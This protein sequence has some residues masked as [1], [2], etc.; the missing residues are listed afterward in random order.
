ML[1]DMP[2]HGVSTPHNSRQAYDLCIKRDANSSAE[3][4][5]DAVQKVL[6]TEEP[7]MYFGISHGGHLA[8]KMAELDPTDRVTAICGVDISGVMTM[9]TLKLQFGYG[10]ME[11]IIGRKQY[12][13]RL[14]GSP[15]E[16]DYMK[17]KNAHDTFVHT[18]SKNFASNNKALFLLNLFS[19]I[20]ASPSAI[21]AWRNIMA[22]KSATVDVVT[23]GHSH[24]SSA[25]HIQQFID[26]LSPAERTRSRQTVLAKENHNMCM[27]Y[28]LPRAVSWA[29][30]AYTR[31]A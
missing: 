19:S 7:L 13:K 24:V 1:L 16:T 2:G 22:N 31:A 10:V 14:A 6:G 23:G 26:S 20:N 29:E 12:L 27:A 15:A 17:F 30:E 11:C 3:P 28:L 9:P 4:M 21:N 5:V 18:R 8:L 25:S